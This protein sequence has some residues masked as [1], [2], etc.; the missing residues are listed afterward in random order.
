ME[1]FGFTERIKGSTTYLN[2]VTGH[3]KKDTGGLHGTHLHC[4]EL[5]INEK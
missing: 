5:V 1:K 3:T 4:G 2:T